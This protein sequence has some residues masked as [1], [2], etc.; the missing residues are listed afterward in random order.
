VENDDTVTNKEL[1]CIANCTA[2]MSAEE[3]SELDAD[4][5]NNSA[6]TSPSTSNMA[7]NMD[8]DNPR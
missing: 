2:V 4:N 5:V 3:N 7:V 6:T 8:T 1:I